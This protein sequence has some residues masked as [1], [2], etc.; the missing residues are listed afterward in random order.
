MQG[1]M[2]ARRRLWRASFGILPGHCVLC[3]A[4]SLQKLDLCRPCVAKLPRLGPH[5]HSCAAPLPLAETDP[6]PGKSGL[7]CGRC[8][9]K[10]PRFD[11]VRTP[12]LYAPPLDGLLSR[13]KFNSD[14]VAGK[15][16]GELLANELRTSFYLGQT[17]HSSKP[18][19]PDWM[20]PI[21]LHW[22]RH[23]SRGFNQ[24]RVLADSLADT[25]HIPVADGLIK[26]NKATQAQRQLRRNERSKN[27]KHAFTLASRRAGTTIEGQ[28]F[29]VVDDIVTT[30]STAEAVAE[31]LKQHGAAAVD[32]WAVARTRL[33]N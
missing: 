16:L 27:V 7:R 9:I 8:Q 3:R 20:I 29:A 10:P 23:L 31:L 24:A 26:R 11:T 4:A 15:L 33:E 13:F 32:I 21:P 18:G 22:R 28:N 19:L 6:G 14:L 2:K 25:L 30:G 5:C 1:S 12:Y 17:S